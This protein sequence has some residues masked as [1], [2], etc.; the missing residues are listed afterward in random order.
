[1]ESESLARLK[2]FPAF[3]ILDWHDSSDRV[4]AIH[5]HHYLTRLHGFELGAEM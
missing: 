5:D 1:M 2:D 4:F 3:L